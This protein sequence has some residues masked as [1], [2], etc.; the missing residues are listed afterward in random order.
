MLEKY[1]NINIERFR[2]K[3]TFEMEKKIV[4]FSFATELE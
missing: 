2:F 3:W 4:F 1:L